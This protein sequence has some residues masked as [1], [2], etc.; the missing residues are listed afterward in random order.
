MRVH[1]P[2]DRQPFR[3]HNQHSRHNASNGSVTFSGSNGS[4]SGRS[5]T[6]CRSVTIR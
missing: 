4:K 3:A 2:V 1:P 6:M 5:R